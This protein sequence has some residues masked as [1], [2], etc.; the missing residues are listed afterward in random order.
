MSEIDKFWP[1][2][3]RSMIRAI[4]L[5]A[6]CLI[7]VKARNLPKFP[8]RNGKKEK[9]LEITWKW[10]V[11]FLVSYV[12][13]WTKMSFVVQPLLFAAHFAALWRICAQT[14]GRARSNNDSVLKAW[15][16]RKWIV[17]K[18]IASLVYAF[19]VNV[20]YRWTKACLSSNIQV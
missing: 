1:R 16:L 11:H 17:S 4:W 6:Y 13:I 20:I 19:V 8:H 12:H 14:N 18:D 2:Y 9:Y 15:L 7:N 10:S 3:S 5:N